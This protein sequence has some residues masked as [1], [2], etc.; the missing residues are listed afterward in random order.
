M[1][2]LGLAPKR[3]DLQHLAAVSHLKLSPAVEQLR[4]Q[5]VRTPSCVDLLP[6]GGPWP[7]GAPAEGST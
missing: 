1:T 3:A 6:G 7:Q 5:V 4:T 2:Q